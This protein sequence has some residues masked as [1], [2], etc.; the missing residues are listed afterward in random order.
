[1]LVQHMMIP[2]RLSYAC[3]THD[4]NTGNCQ[5]EQIVRVH[6]MHQA[7]LS[8]TVSSPFCSQTHAILAT[9]RT[10]TRVHPRQC[11]FVYIALTDFNLSIECDT[12]RYALDV[13]RRNKAALQEM[14]VAFGLDIVDICGETMDCVAVVHGDNVVLSTSN[15]GETPNELQEQTVTTLAGVCVALQSNFVVFSQL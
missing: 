8:L 15:G 2:S 3:A 10:S 11:L 14:G 5:H 13:L 7:C 9:A 6:L 1:M 12:S 4:E